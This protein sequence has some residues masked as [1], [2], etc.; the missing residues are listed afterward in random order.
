MLAAV[1]SLVIAMAVSGC[2]GRSSGNGEMPALTGAIDG[3]VYTMVSKGSDGA[4]DIYM[5]LSQVTVTCGGKSFV[6]PASGYFLL[7]NMSAAEY[8]CTFSKP[9]YRIY[10]VPVQVIGGETSHISAAGQYTLLLDPSATGSVSISSSPAGASVIIDGSQLAA[11]AAT[12]ISLNNVAAGAHS[13]TV[14]LAGYEAPAVQTATVTEN[15]DTALVFPL[16]KIITDISLT[17]DGNAAATIGTPLQFTANCTYADTTTGDCT[18]IVEWQSSDTT[19]AAIGATGILTAITPGT[20]TVSAA[21]PASGATSDTVTV[22]TACPDG[23]AYYGGACVV[24]S[25]SSI[26]IAPSA[27][28]LADGETQLLTASCQW[29]I[30]ALA[31]P[32][33]TWH[34]TAPAAASVNS[35]GLVTGIGPGTASVTATASG[36]TSNASTVTVTAGE[37]SCSGTSGLCMDIIGADAAAGDTVQV[38]VRMDNPPAAGLGAGVASFTWDSSKLSFVSASTGSGITSLFQFTTLP[39]EYRIAFQTT[40]AITSS[41]TLFTVTLRVTP[42]TS[43]QQ[44]PVNW[45]TALQRTNFTDY[46]MALI[47]SSSVTLKN[48]YIN[49][50]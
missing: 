16:T 20:T 17:P 50:R 12:D 32:A 1:F 3:Y 31:C 23:Q 26:T 2:G 49:V 42:G 11:T 41:Q 45:D 27:I 13:I 22:T 44:L 33:L 30:G 6:S 48:A 46:N 38:A 29:N 37:P 47:Q 19:V 28:S 18:G 35:G 15:E 34:T 25:L 5:P 14:S 9:G 4:P 24:A 21:R 10:S 7:S 36:K 40:H 43:P 39:G 8:T